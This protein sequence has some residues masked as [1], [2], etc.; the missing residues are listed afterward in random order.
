MNE[1]LQVA[2]GLTIAAQL[3]YWFAFRKSTES[4]SD[5]TWNACLL[6]EYRD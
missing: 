4:L 3:A 2:Y 5:A 1:I 6:L